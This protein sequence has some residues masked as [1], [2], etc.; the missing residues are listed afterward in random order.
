MQLWQSDRVF[1]ETDD[2]KVRWRVLYRP[3]NV[4][5]LNRLKAG[6]GLA[7]EEWPFEWVEKPEAG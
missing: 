5:E 2:G 1:A 4:R 3:Y 7:P 6:L